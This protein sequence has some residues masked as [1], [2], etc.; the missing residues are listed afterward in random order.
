MIVSEVKDSQLFLR[1]LL[2]DVI[3]EDYCQNGTY[4]VCL[5]DRLSGSASLISLALLVSDNIRE[6]VDDSDSESP[7]LSLREVFVII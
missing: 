7:N 6:T 3:L 5:L 2:S 4:L 1:I